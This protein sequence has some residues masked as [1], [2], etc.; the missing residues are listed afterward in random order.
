VHSPL[1]SSTSEMFSGS[2]LLRLSTLIC[3]GL[4]SAGWAHGQGLSARKMTA[5]REG[6]VPCH[7]LLATLSSLSREPARYSP[8]AA[9]S[10]SPSENPIM[11]GVAEGGLSVVSLGFAA[12]TFLY[13]ALIGLT[14]SDAR[15]GELK[16]KLRRA[17]YATVLAVVSAAILTVLAFVSIALQLSRLGDVAI[18]LALF[19]LALLSGISIYL[20]AD[21]YMEGRR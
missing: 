13:G 20:A 21:V 7:S 15:V 17:L 11:K 12:F 16:K 14:G 1:R 4:I 9:Q 18:A 5:A 3:A 8:S 19:V 6:S 10:V 2:F